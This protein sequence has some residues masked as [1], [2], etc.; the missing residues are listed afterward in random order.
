MRKRYYKSTVDTKL[1]FQS[2]G[3]TY[4]RVILCLCDV[5]L[6]AKGFPIIVNAPQPFAVFIFCCRKANTVCRKLNQRCRE[7][8]L[9]SSH[10]QANTGFTV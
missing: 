5:I 4:E 1:R 7:T 3:I 8:K 9:L 2:F 10:K 6:C